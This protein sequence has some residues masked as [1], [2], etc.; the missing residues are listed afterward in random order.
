MNAEALVLLGRLLGESGYQ[1]VTGT[2]ETQR[3]VNARDGSSGARSLRDVFGWSRSF[4]AGVLPPLMLDALRA[5]NALDE[6]GPELRS[7]VRFSTLNG[8]IYAHSAYPTTSEDAVFFGPDTYRF[9]AFLAREMR[10][11][12]RLVD[13]GCGSGAGGLRVAGLAER[14]VL[15]D[16]NGAALS[17]ARVNAELGGHGHRVEVCESDVL[18]GVEGSLDV[19]VANPPYLVDARKRAYRDGGAD[20]GTELAI[21]IVREALTRLSPGG[22]LLVYTGA[23]VIAGDDVFLR[24]AQ[25]VLDRA[26]ARWTYEE[27]DPDVFGEELE[28]PAYAGVERIAAV[29]LS[30]TLPP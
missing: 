19:V 30:A 15:A 9:C 29:G 21:R 18:A 3:R 4:A 10:P 20:H 7:R 22:R 12:R 27:L 2:P 6:S 14:V 25:P 11:A 1:F 17:L 13:V 24:A 16:I 28:G 5:A 23:P 8:A 26:G